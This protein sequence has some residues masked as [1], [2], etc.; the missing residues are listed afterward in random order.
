MAVWYNDTMD[1]ETESGD[2]VTWAEVTWNEGYQNWPGRL[3]FVE[4][5]VSRGIATVAETKEVQHLRAARDKFYVSHSHEFTRGPEGPA[6]Y[7]CGH[8]HE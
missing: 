8:V 6:C 1:K 4:A 2:Q 7:D 5:R 3:R